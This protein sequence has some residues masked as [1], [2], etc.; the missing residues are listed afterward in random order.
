MKTVVLFALCLLGLLCNGCNRVDIPAFTSAAIYGAA[1][2]NALT[3]PHKLQEFEKC[4][5]G[6]EGS[7]SGSPELNFVGVCV[8]LK[9]GNGAVAHLY[10]GHE[11]IGFT[12]FDGHGPQA[13]SRLYVKRISKSN[14]ARLLGFLPET[15][16]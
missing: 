6:L 14:A 2:G 16:M 3:E 13:G 1:P 9:R 7:W 11:W 4:L 5:R 12:P 15:P 8:E 10:I